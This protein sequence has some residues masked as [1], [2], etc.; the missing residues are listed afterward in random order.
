MQRQYQIRPP[1]LPDGVA[2][3]LPEEALRAMQDALPLHQA[4]PSSNARH[5]PDPGF[6]SAGRY[7]YLEVT[8]RDLA[9]TPGSLRLAL[10][11]SMVYAHCV[12]GFVLAR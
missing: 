5:R 12:E 3:A 2:V 1:A 11:A 4:L 9:P 10:L 7:T 6:P 8:D